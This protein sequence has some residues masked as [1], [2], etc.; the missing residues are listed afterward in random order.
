MGPI[1]NR[2]AWLQGPGANCNDLGPAGPRPWHL[3]LLGP[4]GVGKGTQAERIVREFGACQLSTGDLFRSAARDTGG[5]APSAAMA[6][7]LAAMKRGELVSDGTVVEL[8]RERAQCLACRYGFLLD[9]FPRTIDQAQALDGILVQVNRHLDAAINF[10]AP[11]ALIVER[12]SGR[13]LCK[14][15]RL[16]YHLVNKPPRL[17]GRCDVCGGELI[18]RE[19]DQ[20]EAIRI[21]L[22][23]YAATCDP[24]LAYYRRQGLLRKID[25]SGDPEAV[26]AHTREVMQSLGVLA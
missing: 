15:C 1:G 6:M 13:R 17:P 23:A 8:V 9:G 12:L 16:S 11:E 26:F 18:Q 3:V 25:A 10:F 19:D 4:P 2:I 22:R 14:Q 20:P 24:V 7:A 21:R 5:R